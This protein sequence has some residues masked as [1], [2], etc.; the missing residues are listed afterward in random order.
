MTEQEVRLALRLYICE[1]FRTKIAFAKHIGKS[2]AFITAITTDNEAIKKQI[3]D[4]V[5]SLLGINRQVLYVKKA[6]VTK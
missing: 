6:K 4:N 3:P 1:H 2:C 5:L